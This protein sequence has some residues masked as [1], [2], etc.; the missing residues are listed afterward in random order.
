MKAYIIPL[1]FLSLLFSLNAFSQ[2]F[3]SRFSSV[4]SFA[5]TVKYKGDLTSLT[6]NLTTPYSEQL[7]KARKIIKKNNKNIRYNNKY[8]KKTIYKGKDT[9][10]FHCRDEKNCEAK[11]EN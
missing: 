6:Q 2:E 10:T 4:D 9:K 1:T 8:Y 7:F 5:K 11:M 3:T